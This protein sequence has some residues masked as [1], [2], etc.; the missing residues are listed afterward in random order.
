MSNPIEAAVAPLK[1]DAIKRAEQE[2]NKLVDRV[3]T[4][5]AAAGNDLQKCAPYPRTNVDRM[6]YQRY[7]S[8]YQLFH[9]ICKLRAATRR[10]DDP[11][12][13]DVNDALVLR[14]IDQA[15]A[16]AAAQ[17]EAF[18]A[19]LISKIGGVTEAVLEGNHVWS[20]SYLRVVTAA[21][22]QQTWKT[23][24]IVNVSKLGKLFNQWPTR[25]VKA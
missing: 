3:R 25:K 13:A 4:E 5:L 10:L 2:A 7:L 8:R 21:G 14:F 17:Y 22:E 15:K 9:A 1:A 11:N 6:T 24:Q 16:D 20:Y 12:Y 19:K 23:Q 18:V